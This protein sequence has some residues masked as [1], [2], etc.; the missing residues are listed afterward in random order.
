MGTQTGIDLPGEAPGLVPTV[1]WKRINYS[2]SWVT[3]DTYNMSIGQGFVLTTPLQVLNSAAAVANGGTLYRPQIVGEVID[4][5]GE[6]VRAFSPDVVRQLPISPENIELVRQGMWSAVNGAGATAWAIDVP[7]ITVAGKTGTAEYFVDRNKD[8]IPDRDREGNL[9]THAW[10][11]TFAP[12]EDPEIALVVFVSG[13]GE[14]SA[15]AVPI[16]NEILNYYFA[17]DVVEAQG[18]PTEPG[19]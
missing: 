1:K 10:F 12:Y 8:G 14:G 2:E 15:A 17:P 18:S 4:G 9:P 3:G 7:G 13:G 19:Q 5:D 16:A 11:T 6:V